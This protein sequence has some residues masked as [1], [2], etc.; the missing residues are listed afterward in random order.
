MQRNGFRQIHWE[1]V[2]NTLCYFW[3]GHHFSLMCSCFL[4]L[5]LLFKILFLLYISDMYPLVFFDYLYDYLIWT[6]LHWHVCTN[7]IFEECAFLTP[8]KNHQCYAFHLR[9][10]L[11]GFHVIEMVV[12][13]SNCGAFERQANMRADFILNGS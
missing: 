10:V 8:N 6:K 11:S 9:W 13:T 5:I 2:I 12:E 4:I 3:T 7:P 1:T